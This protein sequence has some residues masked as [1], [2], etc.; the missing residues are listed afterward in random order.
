MD[1]LQIIEKII[2]AYDVNIRFYNE[3]L[4]GL[5]DYDGGLRKRLYMHNSE[6]EQLSAA[7]LLMQ[8]KNLYVE[9]DIYGCSYTL[10]VLP[11]HYT[12][13]RYCII[14]PWRYYKNNINL[15]ETIVSNQI[16]NS[17]KNGFTAYLY[18]IPLIKD[19]TCWISLQRQLLSVLYDG[20]DDIQ[21]VHAKIMVERE[22]NKSDYRKKA[23][24]ISDI[25]YIVKIYQSENDILEA[26]SKGD[27]EFI[28]TGFVNIRAH[29]LMP[30]S[31]NL[32]KSYKN[33]GIAL[34]TLIRK[35]VE[36]KHVHPAIIHE[37]YAEISYKIERATK[38]EDFTSI[39]NEM[40][41]RYC[42]LVK[43]ESLREYSPLIRNVINTINF[44]LQAPLSLKALAG[45]FNVSPGY[46]STQFK[47][48]S[49]M[50]LTDYINFRRI[51]RGGHLLEV[52]SLPIQQ[53]AE[54]CGFL[55]VNYFTRLFKRQFGTTPRDYRR[56][57]NQ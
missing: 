38:P 14:G 28:Q 4:E 27:V 36:N 6:L 50:T 1:K 48:E 24:T 56:A 41:R 3:A 13:E 22:R 55:D 32:L 8:P 46:L 20:A 47:R 51:E 31:G 15:D 37:V 9:K 7:M 16:P 57:A 25:Q 29:N 12:E 39:F 26:V 43:E 23:E 42:K 11:D 18:E 54:N 17:M 34:N 35:T 52:T 21:Q 5:E 2:S 44:N 33:Y 10:F 40:V 45:Q 30:R 19:L 49:T 53:I